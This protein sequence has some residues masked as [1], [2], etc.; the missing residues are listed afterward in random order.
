MMM[1]MMM[2][3]MMVM[4]TTMVG[5][6]TLSR[7][8]AVSHLKSGFVFYP[9]QAVFHRARG[10]SP[11]SPVLHRVLSLVSM[12]AAA[13]PAPLANA[14]AVLDIIQNGARLAHN[15][16][17]RRFALRNRRAGRKIK[18]T[19][20][21]K[22]VKAQILSF[23]RSG[24]ART[25]DF[26]MMPDGVMRGR[27][28]GSGMW[29][30][31]EPEAII[32]T[33]FTPATASARHM[34]SSVQGS[35]LHATQC[36]HVVSMCIVEG[37]DRGVCALNRQSRQSMF[38]FWISNYMFDESRIP[39]LL[40]RAG[41]RKWPV[42]A[43]HGQ[44]TWASSDG[45]VSD[46]DIIKRPVA[47]RHATAAC[48]WAASCATGDPTW[49]NFADDETVFPQASWYATLISSD[50]GA[51][52]LLLVKHLH[53]TLPDRHLCLHSICA[54]HRTGA[55]VEDI[56]R[57]SGLLPPLFCTANVF[58]KGD[59]FQ[60]IRDE[61]CRYLEKHLRVLP[62]EEF[63]AN[64]DDDRLARALLE[65]FYVGHGEQ[66]EK[67]HAKRQ[68]D[69]DAFLSF[70]HGPWGGP[71]VHVCPAGCCG[72]APCANK[73]ET[74]RKAM[75]LLNT[76]IFRHLEV[77]AVN[78]WTKV[79]PVFAKVFLM[80]S[81]GKLMARAMR[82]KMGV[83]DLDE[84]SD[85]SD[86]AQVGAPQDEKRTHKKL[87]SKRKS[88]TLDFIESKDT[89]WRMLLWLSICGVVMVVHYRLFKFGT[90]HSHCN[91]QRCGT[92]E[93]VNRSSN[94]A[95]K[96]MVVLSF[97]ICDPMGAGREHWL[98]MILRYGPTRA[99]P[100]KIMQEAQ[101]SIIRTF[102]AL[103]RR[104]VLPW[105]SYP[106]LLAHIV[107]P[108]ASEES[109]R[110]AAQA[111]FNKGRT[112]PCCLDHY[113]G[114]KLHATF[115]TWEALFEGDV[116]EFLYAVFSRA[117]VT[118]TFVER[119]FSNLSAWTINRRLS[120]ASLQAMH[121]TASFSQ[122]VDRSRAM[123]D[124]R[125]PTS[126]SRPAWIRPYAKGSRVTGLHLFQKKHEHGETAF[127]QDFLNRSRAA[128][129]ALPQ[130]AKTQYERRAQGRRAIASAVE[131]SPLEQALEPVL[132]DDVEFGPW[133]L[134]TQVGLP[135]RS[136]VVSSATC[137]PQGFKNM[138]AKWA[139]DSQHA[140]T[141]PLLHSTHSQIVNKN[142]LY[143]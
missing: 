77:P 90:W 120:L 143:E 137:G 56:T 125:R 59:F 6:D 81:F 37:Q 30:R 51:P 83:D 87:S 29:K 85:L 119:V 141:T 55:V 93:F 50:G 71:L 3:T 1:T 57:K 69:V 136:G 89:L 133:G 2:M 24:N 13:Q 94:P 14:W 104:L 5:D 41:F 18:A 100:K 84:G 114:K 36:R 17:R 115:T 109:R 58:A 12:D 122:A 22:Q 91:D 110:T 10:V 80:A 132:N 142:N 47:L 16:Q 92:F 48:M 112:R 74:L 101:S 62:P 33:A 99:W 20:G 39:V 123:A 67:S 131:K 75:D 25:A 135:L 8:D 23:N 76:V 138:H 102:C 72:E 64:V 60:D 78:K 134:G 107:D 98:P 35:P 27:L 73:E 65:M 34:A 127:G 61:V 97:M 124:T 21:R 54:Q 68:Q 88:K 106:W 19:I 103:W 38:R 70:F 82:A 4:T 42:L 86:D 105:A 108:S 46:Q 26:V 66:E 9:P 140:H 45:V 118:S 111:F 116:H 32:K 117:V 126:K 121:V 53:N 63:H 43:R 31:W 44:L 113:F 96:A 95:L 128:W 79:F 129:A 52:N 11:G 7:S 49:L 40:E 28:R 139:K 15:L 130:D